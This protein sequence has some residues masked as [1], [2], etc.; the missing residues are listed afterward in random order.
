MFNTKFNLAYS[1]A[2]NQFYY[3]NIPTYIF[4]ELYKERYFDYEVLFDCEQLIILKNT[5][6]EKVYY[7]SPIL[8]GLE[9]L[10][11]KKLEEIMMSFKDVKYLLLLRKVGGFIK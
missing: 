8:K 10:T 11:T 6:D 5:I 3:Y 4:E 1:F 7:L 2:L 9:E